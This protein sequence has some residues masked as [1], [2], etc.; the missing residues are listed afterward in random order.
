MEFELWYL[1]VVPLLFA[2]GW[3]MRGIDFKQHQR[4][5]KGL[6]DHYFK[7]LSLLLS[8]EP[9]KAIDLFIEVV[10]LDPETI[11]LHHALGNLFRRRGQFDRAIR[12]HNFLVNRAEL[13][14]AERAKALSELALDYLKAGMYD[15]AE[16]AY[17]ALAHAPKHEAEAREAL[18]RIY[19]TEREWKKAVDEAGRLAATGRDLHVEI[20]HYYCE[21]AQLSRLAKDGSRALEYIRSALKANP[22]NPRA[23][24]MQADLALDAGD[25]SAALQAWDRLQA[26]KPAYLP[27]I[28]AKKADV[29]AEN[30]SKAALEYLKDVFA[31]TGSV[32]VL[33]AT[34]SRIASWADDSKAAGF[35]AEALAKRPSLSSFSVLC[36]LRAKLNPDDQQA[37][38]LADITAK[39]SKFFARYQCRNCGFLAHTFTWQCPGCERWD[40]FPPLRADEVQKTRSY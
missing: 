26:V 11:E 39:Q 38:L 20:S 8:D 17:E 37:K 21:L 12:I 22:E 24:A 13:P 15:R 4:E 31:Q 28:A 1:I 3:W 36:S 18:M 6:D 35:A 9:D 25:R 19:C 32:D 33:N 16:S 10:R 29:M 27:L 40:S 30:D 7:G 2:A 34:V 5:T 14:E 23:I